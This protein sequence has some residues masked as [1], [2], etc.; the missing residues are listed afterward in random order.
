MADNEWPEL[1]TSLPEADIPFEG[2][3]GWLLQGQ[4]HQQVFF[5]IEP[6]GE[7][8]PHRH[9]A[10][11]GIMVN[12]EMKLTIGGETR[13][14]KTGDSYFI[15]AGV[16]HSATFLTRCRLIDFFEDARRYTPRNEQPASL[17]TVEVS[18]Q[19]TQKFRVAGR[20]SHRGAA[21]WP[22]PGGPSFAKAKGGD[23]MIG[24]RKGVRDQSV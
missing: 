13:H 1:I 19:I 5:D 2:V 9:G 20:R 18:P 6:I 17:F 14:V 24:H 23:S 3:R 15:P 7:V 22:I 8:P 4:G 21:G 11:W 12:G 10:Q 16:Q